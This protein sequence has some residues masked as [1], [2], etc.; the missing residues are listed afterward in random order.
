MNRENQKILKIITVTIAIAVMFIAFLLCSKISK[1]QLLDDLRQNLDLQI[2][3]DTLLIDGRDMDLITLS[4]FAEKAIAT[5]YCDTVRI[6][7]GKIDSISFNI[8]NQKGKHIFFRGSS[9]Q[10]MLKF[11]NLPVSIRENGSFTA[12]I[13]QKDSVEYIKIPFQ[14]LFS[15]I[16]PD[17]KVGDKSTSIPVSEVDTSD[18][19]NPN[20]I[21]VKHINELDIV[22]EKQLIQVEGLVY[23][24]VSEILAKSGDRSSSK[25]RHIGIL[26]KYA[27]DHWLYINDPYIGYDKWRSATETIENYY[28]GKQETYTGDCDDFAILVASFARQ[29]GLRSRFVGAV[30]KQGGHAF[31][32][33][34]VPNSEIDDMKSEIGKNLDK[35]DHTYSKNKINYYNGTGGIWVNMDWWG[36]TI[37]GPYYEGKR[38]II[39]ENL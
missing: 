17:S 13:T 24:N 16:N 19:D 25:Y 30:S 11:K 7:N 23:N 26:W 12:V 27:Y 33:F 36:N 14:I 37:G 38:D 29:V 39:K 8:T 15:L 35:N 6:R 22:N 31:A 18:N 3:S 34:F 10:K 21:T 20:P 28:F 4:K 9:M 5:T 2:A 32:E 1:P